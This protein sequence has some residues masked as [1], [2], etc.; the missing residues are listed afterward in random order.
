MNH[1]KK[2]RTFVIFK[3]DVIQRSLMGEIINRLERTGLKLVA[4][5]MIF[6]TEDQCWDHYNKDDAWFEEKGA[7]IV[8]EREV[9][10]GDILGDSIEIKEGLNIED[11]IL[12]KI[13]GISLEEE[14]IIK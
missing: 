5:K 9:V 13:A 7:N 14:V 4:Q 1:P 11:K 6:A 12:S 2:E 8:K 10:V 3:P